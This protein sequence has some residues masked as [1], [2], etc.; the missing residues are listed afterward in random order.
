MEANFCRHSGLQPP[1]PHR[2]SLAVMLTRA[3]RSLTIFWR[4]Y[5]FLSYANILQIICI[6]FL[7]TQIFGPWK[8]S[9]K[10]G[11]LFK[12]IENQQGLTLWI[13][14]FVQIWE[15]IFNR[16][17]RQEQILYRY[18]NRWWHNKTTSL[19]K[20]IKDLATHD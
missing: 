7:L 4:S 16:S 12:T 14:K 6:P 13:N 18:S 5:K 10:S 8:I 11:K 3:K 20:I 19:F 1:R 15:D 9:K 2:I 17:W